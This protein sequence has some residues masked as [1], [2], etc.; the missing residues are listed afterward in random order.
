MIA[1]FDVWYLLD[2][3]ERRS[4]VKYDK[5]Y[6]DNSIMGEVYHKLHLEHGSGG[7]QQPE[8]EVIDLKLHELKL[9]A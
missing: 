3:R 9:E 8:I 4:K 6:Q 7:G 1:I 5:P 2:G